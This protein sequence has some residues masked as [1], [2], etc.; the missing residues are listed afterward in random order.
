MRTMALL[1]ALVIGSPAVF[2]CED[3]LV[4]WEEFKGLYRASIEREIREE[5]GPQEEA[6]QVHSIDEARYRLTIG[7]EDAR[8]EVLLSG[9]VISGGPEP[10]PLFGCEAVITELKGVTGGAV[11]CGED[12]T[13]VS[14]VPQGGAGEFA[15]TACFLVR[16]QEEEASRVI[17]FDIPRAVRNSLAVDLPAES[18][19][20]EHPGIADADGIYH[21]SASP[22]LTIRYLDP[23]GP[24][25][26]TIVEIDSVSRISVQ[27]NRLLVSTWFLP[28]RAAPDSL[29]LDAPA[30]AEYIASSLKASQVEQLDGDRYALSIPRG[31]ASP[32]SV[33]LALAMATDAGEASFS[34]PRIEGNSGQEGRFV[35][36]EPADGQATASASGL[37]SQIPIER[38]GEALAE[39]VED[40]RFYMSV[41]PDEPIAL[42]VKRFQAVSTPATVLECQYLFTS[43]EENGNILSVLVM[44]IPPEFGSRM[45]LKAVADCEVWSLVVNGAKKRVF[46]D[47]A[48]TWVIPLDSGAVSHVELAFLGNGPKLG[49]QGKLEAIV[50]ETGLASRELRVGLALPARVELLCTE[51][52]LSGAPGENWKLPAEFVGKRH[53][54]SRSFYKGEGMTLSISY[55]EPVNQVGQKGGQR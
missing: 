14:F 17:S 23:R 4:P 51:G 41:S 28:V 5:A 32:F 10:I 35:L 36:E 21:F 3:V 37:V 45:T 43:F 49:L 9:R 50:P 20:L 22:R 30:G 1:V 24:A 54:F 13:R 8:G 16:P 52:P 42:T 44:D 40:S 31:E 34:L 18:R 7:G 48:D 2:G 25:A 38:L 39:C 11:L 55:K 46:A 15:V 47:E 27:R 29:I 33:E 12:E 26:A 53:F 19:V 6:P